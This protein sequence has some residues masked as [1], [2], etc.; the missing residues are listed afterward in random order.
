[1]RTLLLASLAMLALCTACGQKGPLVLPQKSVATPVLIH[2]PAEAAPA[3]PAVTPAP[4]DAPPKAE[5][6]DDEPAPSPPKR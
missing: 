2:G 5:R 4:A 3:A 1:M 6:K